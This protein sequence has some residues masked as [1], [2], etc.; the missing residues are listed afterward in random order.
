MRI[1]VFRN[2]KAYIRIKVMKINV[3]MHSDI[4]LTYILYIQPLMMMI[5]ISEK[6]LKRVTSQLNLM[7]AQWG[8]NKWYK[9]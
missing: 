1:V 6:R 8:A 7:S 9:L 2:I 4:E 3:S 5:L